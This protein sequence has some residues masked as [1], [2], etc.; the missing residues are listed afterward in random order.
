MRAGP[1]VRAA[2][3]IAIRLVLLVALLLAGLAAVAARAVQLQVVDRERLSE[4]ARDQHVRQLVLRPRRGAITDRTGVLLAGSADAESVFADPER[5]RRSG[6]AA[7][8]VSR[9]AAALRL[10]A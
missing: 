7:R 2:R 10:D 5:L 9:L 6:G 8:A 3:W 4:E 1:E